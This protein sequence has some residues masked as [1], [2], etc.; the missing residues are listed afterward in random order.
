MNF[1]FKQGLF[2]YEVCSIKVNELKL[3][4]GFYS[5]MYHLSRLHVVRLI[6]LED[7]EIGALVYFS[8]LK[9]YVVSFVRFSIDPDICVLFSDT[10]YQHDVNI[11]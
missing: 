11:T 7:S 10:F 1:W 2:R 8:P 4:V 9:L 6:R 5:E 3:Y